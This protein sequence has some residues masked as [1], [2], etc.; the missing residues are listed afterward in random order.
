MLNSKNLFSGLFWKI[1]LTFFMLL[2]AIGFAYLIISTRMSEEYFIEKNQRLNASIAQSIVQEVKPFINGELSEDATDAIMHHLMAINPSIEVY[3]L[4]AQGNI[5][6]YVAPYKKV[7]ADKVRLA[8]VKKFLQGLDKGIIVG[9][10]P[11]NPGVEKVFSAAEIKEGNRVAGYVY[12]ILASEELDSVTELLKGNYI[13]R[14]G[15]TTMLITLLAAF[16]IGLLVFWIVTKNINRIIATVKKFQQGE[17]SA[18]IP[19][20]K[21]GD[22]NDLAIA[23][24]DMADTIVG[25][26]EN[27]RSME[28][29]RRE[30]VGNVSHDLRTPLAVIHGYI[31]TL[32]M[33]DKEISADDRRRYLNTALESTERLRKLVDELFELSKLEAKQIRPNKEP[34]YIDELIHDVVRKFNIIANKKGIKLEAKINRSG[35]MVYADVALIER[36]LQNL[37]DN[38]IKYTPA[39]GEITLAVD[40]TSENVQIK[41][42]DTGAGIPEDQAPYIFDRYHIGDKRISL[43]KN[44]TGL[45]LA[46]VKRI[47]EIHNTNIALLSNPDRGTT[48]AFDLPKYA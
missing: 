27:M 48:F 20:K 14:L 30:L 21:G 23:F 13:L 29:L 37:V 15:S 28:K 12:V 7:V 9:D 46:I 18:R 36:V 44:S 39:H 1:S 4:D 34:F 8:P 42:T 43:D 25:N 16:V 2:T 6:N 26:I 22:I 5:L 40:D 35:I 33:K 47:L 10:D 45:G 38:A 24:N 31:E 17:F 19:V 11:R 41:V 3:L 32:I